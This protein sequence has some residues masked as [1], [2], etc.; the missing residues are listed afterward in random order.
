[1]LIGARQIGKTYILNRFCHE[2]FDECFY[3]NLELSKNIASIFE[4]T[5]EPEKII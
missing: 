1:M 4:S 2:N 3:C 5:I